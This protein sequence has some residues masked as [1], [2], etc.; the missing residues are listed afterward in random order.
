M[1]RNAIHEALKTLLAGLPGVV[2][3][4]D[5]LESWSEVAA[6][7]QPALF[8]AKGDESVDEVKGQPSIVYLNYRVWLYAHESDRSLSPAIQLNDLIDEVQL[9]LK[10]PLGHQQTL[11]GLVAHASISGS[12]ETD[13]GT[14]GDQA[15]AIIPVRIQTTI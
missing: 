9:R 11:G 15:V 12:I 13:E 4:S 1:T 14:L 10:P 3:F 6:A 2:S 7:E 5:R 8:L